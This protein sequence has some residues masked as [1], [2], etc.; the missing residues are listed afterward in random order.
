M[1]INSLANQSIDSLEDF[2]ARYFSDVRSDTEGL[3]DISKTRR[4]IINDINNKEKINRITVTNVTISAN[5]DM[6]NTEINSNAITN[7][8][9]D[10]N[11]INK[12]KFIDTEK[13]IFSKPNYSNIIPYRKQ[14]LSQFVWWKKISTGQSL[15]IIFL[16]PNIDIYYKSKP[17]TYL[18]YL[19]S[20]SGE[21][22]LLEVL[23]KNK[24][25]NK[26]SSGLISSKESFSLLAITVDLTKL[27]LAKLDTV[28]SLV[29]KYLKLVR[30]S[31]IKDN[32]FNEIKNMEKTKFNFLDKNNDY[33]SYL[34]QLAKNLFIYD[35]EDVLYSDYNY[36]NY[37][38]TIIKTFS[39]KLIPENCLIFVGSDNYPKNI[40]FNKENSTELW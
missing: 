5:I 2:A 15:D 8:G 25:A 4:A 10:N 7:N 1:L 40:I 3:Q 16:L 21:N 34:S 39:D 26:L 36:E 24:L 33:G 31:E 11:N 28:T 30:E 12:N 13:P 19:L 18:S 14:D 29:F 9:N 27:G 23:T 35:Y 20:Y 38:S 32:I 17:T 22:S 6:N 37:N